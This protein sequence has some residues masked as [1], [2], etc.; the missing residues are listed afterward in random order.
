MTTQETAAIYVKLVVSS[1]GLLS[2]PHEIAAALIGA[3]SEHEEVQSADAFVW[4]NNIDTTRWDND[5]IQFARL[6]AEIVAAGGLNNTLI[7][8][9]KLEM[10]LYR[11]EIDEIFERAQGTWDRIKEA[12]HKEQTSCN[13]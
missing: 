10:G 5:Y 3:V 13:E 8:Y 9:L 12:H 2:E 11:G 1:D 4:D 6:L 7:D